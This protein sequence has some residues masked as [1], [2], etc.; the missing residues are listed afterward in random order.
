MY[1]V[2][3]KISVILA[4]INKTGTVPKRKNLHTQ[5]NEKWE[6]KNTHLLKAV[7]NKVFDR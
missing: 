7:S 6:G 5:L 3:T 1:G 4:T 2:N